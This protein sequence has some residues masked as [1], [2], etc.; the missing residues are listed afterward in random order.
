MA[1][2]EDHFEQRC[3]RLG[4]SVS[5][6]YCRTCGDEGLPCWKIFDCWW[7]RFDVVAHLKTYLPEDTV[8]KIANTRPKPKLTSLVEM[9]EQA[10]QRVA[11]GKTN[12]SAGT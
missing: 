1:E 7:E 10:K 3:P 4:G 6:R 2:N 12:S 11:A 9:I 8:N 5:F